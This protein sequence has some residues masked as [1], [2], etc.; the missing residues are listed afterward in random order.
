MITTRIACTLLVAFAASMTGARDVQARMY[1]WLDP[2]S[3]TVQ[4]S[5]EPP[6]W[7]RDGGGGPRVRVFDNGNLVDDTAIE[8]PRGQREQLRE[9]AFDEAEQRRRAEAVQRLERAARQEERRSEELAR[10]EAAREQRQQRQQR[11][12]RERDRAAKEE[13]AD[14]PAP[15]AAGQDVALSG[16]DLDDAT[17]A[18]LKAIIADFDRRGGG[19][20]GQR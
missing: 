10:L 5:G 4:L 17:V 1:Q 3:G 12:Q 2:S 8:L 11:E 20:E 7:Y 19:L 6:G 13:S 18:R 14:Q 15:E 9:A 16:K